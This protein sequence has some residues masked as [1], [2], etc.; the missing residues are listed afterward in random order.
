MGEVEITALNNSSFSIDKEELVVILSPS[1]T[2]KKTTC[3]NILGGMDSKTKG[4]AIVDSV[5]IT[6]LK[7]KG[8]IDY[9]RHR[10]VIMKNRIITN[11]VGTI[12]KY[13]LDLFTI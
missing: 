10:V 12:K 2:G 7:H 13:F 11:S 4:E 1:Y 3:L 9:R 5:D 6:K 8:I